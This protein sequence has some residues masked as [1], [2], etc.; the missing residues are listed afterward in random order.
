MHLTYLALVTNLVT[1]LVGLSFL[2]N[3][4]LAQ[5]FSIHVSAHQGNLYLVVSS[6]GLPHCSS[7]T[8]KVMCLLNLIRILF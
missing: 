7:Y 4:I 1:L 3:G 6:S 2:L 5:N 8:L